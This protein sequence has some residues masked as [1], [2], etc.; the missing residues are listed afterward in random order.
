VRSFGET[1]TALRGVKTRNPAFDVTPNSLI[2][3]IITD[4]ALISPPFEPQLLR[5]FG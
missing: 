1:I 4:E 2:A 3:G 5:L